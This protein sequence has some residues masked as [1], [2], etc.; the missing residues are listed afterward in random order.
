[1]SCI[2]TVRGMSRNYGVYTYHDN[3]KRTIHGNSKRLNS[4]KKQ[5]GENGSGKSSSGQF[6]TGLLISALFVRTPSISPF[7]PA[8]Y[9]TLLYLKPL[10]C[11]IRYHI[12]LRVT[13]TQFLLIRKYYYTIACKLITQLDCSSIFC[14]WS[15]SSLFE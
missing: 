10:P 3:E 5:P 14:P 11:L 1:M 15:A 8:I 9:N 2:R 13:P 7:F 12:L 4:P 6:S